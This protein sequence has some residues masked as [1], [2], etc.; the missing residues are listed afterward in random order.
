MTI[1]QRVRLPLSK[2]RGHGVGFCSWLM[3]EFTIAGVM[4]KLNHPV[5]GLVKYPWDLSP[6]VTIDRRV[7]WDLS[8]ALPKWEGGWLCDEFVDF[9][10]R[11]FVSGWF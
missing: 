2:W 1:D 5:Q 8:P 6:I 3:K 11:C 10:N 4:N 7:G 9:P